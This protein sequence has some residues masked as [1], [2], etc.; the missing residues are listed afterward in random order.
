MEGVCELGEALDGFVVVAHLEKVDD[1]E[2]HRGRQ[3]SSEIDSDHLRTVT[4]LL[5]NS[6]GVDMHPIRTE[7]SP[8]GIEINVDFGLDAGWDS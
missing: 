6:L 4:E 8:H 5:G 1:L 7:E 3:R 2:V